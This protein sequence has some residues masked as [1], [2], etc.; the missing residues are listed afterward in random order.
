[1]KSPLKSPLKSPFRL[2]SNSIT[3]GIWTFISRISGLA[4]EIIF[5]ALFG[6]SAVAEAFQIAFTPAQSVSPDFCRRRV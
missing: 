2:F 1:M 6:S 4:R 3:I 5:A